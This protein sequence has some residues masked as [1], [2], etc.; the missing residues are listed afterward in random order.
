M[1]GGVCKQVGTGLLRVT[2]SGSLLLIPEEAFA[3]ASVVYATVHGHLAARNQLLSSSPR[4]PVVNQQRK[5]QQS[6]EKERFGSSVCQLN[7]GFLP[8][9][10]PSRR[11]PP[12]FPPFLWGVQLLVSLDGRSENIRDARRINEIGAEVPSEKSTECHQESVAG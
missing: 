8:S 4:G 10:P 1:G 6:C 3:T 9:Y 2:P 7:R 12:A 5:F 11:R